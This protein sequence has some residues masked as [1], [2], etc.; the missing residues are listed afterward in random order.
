MIRTKPHVNMRKQ[1]V[2]KV[3]EPTKKS[4]WKNIVFCLIIWQWTKASWEANEH[5][6]GCVK[7]PHHELQF[8]KNSQSYSIWPQTTDNGMW[9]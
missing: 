7:C 3:K 8:L 4:K 2:L 1:E 6:F 5:Q 9:C